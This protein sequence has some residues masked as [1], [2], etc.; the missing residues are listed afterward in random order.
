MVGED[1]AAI[2]SPP[3]HGSVVA[4]RLSGQPRGLL[5]SYAKQAWLLLPYTIAD[6][7]V[8][9]GHR[10]LSEKRTRMSLTTVLIL[11]GGATGGC[12]IDTVAKLPTAPTHVVGSDAGRVV[13]EFLRCPNVAELPLRGPRFVAT[14]ASARYLTGVR[15]PLG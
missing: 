10:V 15:H 2:A 5:V 7:A 9:P 1:A 4:A 8:L 13:P 6:C 3:S 11:G 12:A 14:V